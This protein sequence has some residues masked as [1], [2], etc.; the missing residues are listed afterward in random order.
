MPIVWPLLFCIT[1]LSAWS[2]VLMEVPSLVFGHLPTHWVFGGCR[3]KYRPPILWVKS[4]LSNSIDRHVRPEDCFTYVLMPFRALLYCTN[5]AYTYKPNNKIIIIYNTFSVP[6]QIKRQTTW[7]LIV[8]FVDKATNMEI[9]SS[10]PKAKTRLFIPGD[11]RNHG[12]THF[13]MQYG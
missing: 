8:Y 4:S 9:V 2:S 5:V 7:Q 1:S 12:N 6:I 13:R 3:Y 10:Y 11:K